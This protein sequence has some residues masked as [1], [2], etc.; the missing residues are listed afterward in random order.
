VKIIKLD[1]PIEGTGVNSKEELV[2]L[3]SIITKTFIKK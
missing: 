1:D 3:G 2:K